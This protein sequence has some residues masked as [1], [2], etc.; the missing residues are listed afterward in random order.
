MYFCEKKIL[1]FG[2]FLPILQLAFGKNIYV[3]QL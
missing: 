1:S 3:K 2:G